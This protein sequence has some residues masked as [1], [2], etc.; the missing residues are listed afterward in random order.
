MP[1]PDRPLLI[2]LGVWLAVALAAAFMPAWTAVWQAYATALFALAA[3]DAYAG[4]RRRGRVS[5]ARE[6]PHTLPVGTWQT[7]RLRLRSQAGFAEGW[8][9][10]GHPA[11]FQRTGLPLRF[12]VA[13]GNGLLASYRVSVSERGRHA[14][15][16]VHLRRRSPLRLWQIP[17]SIAA[18][19]E[20]RV[21]P[22]FARIAH[23]TLLATDNRLSQFGILPRRRRGEGLE[24]QQLRD[25]RQDDSP[26]HIDWK[27]SSRVGRLIARDYQD[28]RD[29]QIL[30]L[31]D[32]S[33][34][35]RA[36]DGEL[37]HFD[38]AL[39]ALLL[40]AYVVL[41]QG[42]ALGL[43]TFGHPQPRVLPPGKS[44]A[45]ISALTNAV[46]DLQP[47]RQVP[48][49]LT[50]AETLLRRLRKRALVILVTNLRDEDD[51]TLLPAVRQL[52]RRHALT[53]A[54]LREPFLDELLEAPVED[55]DAALTRAAGLEYRQARQ[56]QIA[57]LGHRGVPVLDV[58]A[59]QLPVALIN[60]YWARKRAGEV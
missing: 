56:R 13:P 20:V 47:S 29:Q 1:L 54:S 49:Y 38:H 2:A 50:A 27:A 7:V 18:Y 59:R 22:N 35:L 37:S 43:V 40:L 25:Y 28:E 55:F 24:F 9:E 52:R 8:L 11:A 33:A 12:S 23:F 53:V 57:L 51:D 16:G 10:D 36:H 42:D 44:L 4:W 31:L 30:I 17:E 26:R 48:D 34:R 6:V 5:V 32:C 21:F 14:F 45:T 60:H 46:Y 19:D 39:N 15:D 41:R 58:G 3:V